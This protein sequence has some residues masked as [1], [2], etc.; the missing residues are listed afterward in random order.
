M[1]NGQY[2]MPLDEKGFSVSFEPGIFATTHTAKLTTSLGVVTV[3]VENSFSVSGLR[4]PVLLKQ[5]V[6]HWSFAAGAYVDLIVSSTQ[7]TGVSAQEVILAKEGD[8][9]SGT[10][11][12][13]GGLIGQV[14]YDFKW[15][16]VSAGVTLPLSDT[17]KI[18]ASKPVA[19]QFGL[20]TTF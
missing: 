5:R 7:K 18:V 15:V 1:I 13:V 14:G 9:S 8:V 11:A 2:G 3:G 10:N 6:D 12:V 4:L 17:Y 20:A 16:Q 19:F